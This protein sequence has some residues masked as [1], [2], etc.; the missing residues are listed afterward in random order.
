MEGAEDSAAIDGARQSGDV[1]TPGAGGKLALAVAI[2]G[3]DATPAAS[4]KPKSS[5]TWPVRV[6]SARPS[7]CCDPS[8]EK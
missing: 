6:R 2:G 8:A 4:L 5:P 7:R 1:I 3:G